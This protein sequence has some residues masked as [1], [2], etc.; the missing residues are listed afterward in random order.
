MTNRATLWILVSVLLSSPGPW[1]GHPALAAGQESSTE[2]SPEFVRAVLGAGSLWLRPRVNSCP[3]AYVE[4]ADRLCEVVY[5]PSRIFRVPAG[6]PVLVRSVKGDAESGFRINL[7]SQRFGR[8]TLHFKPSLSAGITHA[9][10]RAMVAAAFHNDSGRATE[11]SVT[12]NRASHMAHAATCNHLPP[13]PDREPLAS[14]E[15]AL[16][17]GFELC[18]ICF[19]SSPR[20][21]GY[22]MELRLGREVARLMRSAYSFTPDERLQRRLERSG[23]DVLGRWIAPLKGYRYRFAVV[24]SDEPNAV[25]CPAGTIYFTS[26]LMYALETDAELEAALAHEIAHVELRH[27]YRQYRSAMKGALVSALLAV[28]VGAVV[29]DQSSD[30]QPGAHVAKWVAE[31]GAIATQIV[32][33]G[34]SRDHEAEADDFA[35]AYLLRKTDAQSTAPLTSVL[36]KLRYAAAMDG[37]IWALNSAF[38]THPDLETRIARIGGAEVAEFDS[39]AV[40]WGCDA[41]GDLLL[42]VRLVSQGVSSYR[43]AFFLSGKGMKTGAQ[44][45]MRPS[46]SVVKSRPRVE[47]RMFA[48]VESTADLA[49]RIQ[50]NALSVR[51]GGQNYTLSNPEHT[52]LFPVDEVSAVFSTQD[53]DGLIVGPIEGIRLPY[54]RDVEHWIRAGDLD[55]LQEIQTPVNADTPTPR[56]GRRR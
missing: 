2:A 15:K 21:S 32:L 36:A 47:Y 3:V 23:A 4:S 53:V 48:T 19:A 26:A 25:A 17:A 28:A 1:L 12:G 50:L 7:G 46:R 29:A 11:P 18:P 52:E 40:F 35:M 56:R 22:R 14:A 31:L 45:A 55:A 34:Y 38:S 37:E 8:G 10:V 27:G 44:P 41:D 54:V 33:A 43:E 6:L 24:E 49:D 16:A 9:D 30:L 39:S 5:E 13:V 20:L 51:A 42:T